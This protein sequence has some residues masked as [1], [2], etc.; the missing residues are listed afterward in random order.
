MDARPMLSTL[1]AAGHEPTGALQFCLEK[2]GRL[3]PFR[4]Q[5]P[6]SQRQNGWHWASV[7][8]SQKTRCFPY[9]MEKV[10]MSN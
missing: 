1:V 8:G 7:Y 10:A 6:P 4:Y 5:A 2:T 3:A 9:E